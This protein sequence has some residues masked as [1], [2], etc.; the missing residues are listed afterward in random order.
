[1]TIKMLAAGFSWIYTFDAHAGNPLV[2][3]A[4]PSFL[5]VRHHIL[6]TQHAKLS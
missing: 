4:P 2:S 3:E 6:S 5:V 1:M